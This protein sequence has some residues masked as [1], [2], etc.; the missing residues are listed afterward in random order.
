M[1]SYDVIVIGAGPSG[2]STAIEAGKH[3]LSCVVIDKGAIADAIRRFP[4]S[5]TFFSTPELLEIGG[6]PFTS[7]GFRP[8]RVECVRYYQTVAR[9]F[10]LE[11]RRGENVLRL[12]KSSGG[13]DVTTDKSQYSAA[14]VVVA[15]G[16]FDN[17]ARFEVPGA[18]LPK[19]I[20][21]YDE[22]YAYEGRN[23]AVVGGRNS[24]VEAAL[25]LFRNGANVT[26]IHRGPTLSEGVKYWILPDIE[27]RIRA[28]E[29]MGLFETRIR[30]IRPQS[31]LLAGKHEIEIP[32][33]F[34]FVMI[35]YR[36][37]TT[38]LE[39]IGVEIN[40]DTLGPV[41]NPETM[42]TN[43]K[44]LYVAGSVA[45][46]KYNNKIFIENGRTHGPVIIKE[47]MRVR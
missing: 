41:Y 6:L 35:G 30:Q 46:G 33:D 20:R 12:R 40:R 7:S 17:P 3:G 27:N 39:D 31:I 28:G 11:V 36:P 38:I 21:Y 1:N 10:Q 22:P 45:A 43:V 23:V 2:L 26:L 13:F 44:G 19:V 24:A 25:D 15:T 5:L 4:V 29:I 8:T 14:S 42:E 16:Y 18:D 32:N 9:H 37:D 34:V 47:I